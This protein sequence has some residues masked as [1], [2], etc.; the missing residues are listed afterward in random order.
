MQD[1][2]LKGGLDL[3][4]AK[5]L[6]QP[7]YLEDCF[8][9]EVGIEPGYQT[10]GGFERF[11]GHISPSNTD[12]WDVAIDNVAIKPSATFTNSLVISDDTT[13]TGMFF[14]ADGA[15]MF[16]VGDGSDR[17]YQY[18]LS[19]PWNITKAV[20]VVGSDP[21]DVSTDDT[22]PQAMAI[23]PDG[24]RA[25]V[26]GTATDI[27][28]TYVL[29]VNTD[30]NSSWT[31]SA[32]SIDVSTEETS[33]T[34]FTFSTDGMRLFVCG[35]QV[36]EV[37]Q[38]DLPAA[39]TLWM[40]DGV[41]FVPAT[42]N[43]SLDISLY[44]T[45]PTGIQF[46]AGG[47][48]FYV[49]DAGGL[50]RGYSCSTAWDISTATW[51][52]EYDT[53]TAI[54][55]IYLTPDSG[56]LF[57]LHTGAT[58]YVREYGWGFSPNEAIDWE[59][60]GE[61]GSLGV[62]ASTDIGALQTAIRFAYRDSAD[63]LPLGATATGTNGASFK[64]GLFSLYDTSKVLSVAAQD[65]NPQAAWFKPDGLRCY[66]L[67]NTN[68]FVYRYNLTIPWDLD[69]AS[70]HSSYNLGAA[71]PHYGLAFRSDGTQF[72]VSTTTITT[73]YTLTTPWDITTVN[74][75]SA[76]LPNG[77]GIT[78]S[79]DG[80]KMYAVQSAPAASVTYP[81][82]SFIHQ[83]TYATAW[84]FGPGPTASVD[85]SINNL[86]LPGEA[87]EEWAVN[88]IAFADDGLSYY[89]SM[90]LLK[91]IH[92]YTCTTAWDVVGS[93]HSGEWFQHNISGINDL[94]ISGHHLYL[95]S[96]Q[97]ELNQYE[98]YN[99]AVFTPLTGVAADIEEYQD[100]LADV[101]AVFR[102]AI[103][104]TPGSGPV[105][106]QKWYKEQLYAVRDYY[107]FNYRSA[108]WAPLK[109]G[110]HVIVCQHNKSI[111]IHGDEGILREL[112]I[113]AGSNLLSNAAGSVLIEPLTNSF[114]WA[115]RLGD[116]LVNS[117]VAGL[118]EVYFNSGSVEPVRGHEMVGATSGF[119]F[120][121][122]RVELRSG[123]WAVGNA[124]GVVY[125]Y[126]VD[127]GIL[128][129]GE[130]VNNTTT[131]TANVMTLEANP[132]IY[133]AGRGTVGNID[134]VGNLKFYSRNEDGAS[135]A[136]LYRTTREGWEKIPL[137][138]EVRFING[139]AEPT[140]IKF[141]ADTSSATVITSDWAVPTS[142]GVVGAW[143]ASAGTVVDAVD[144]S[145]GAYVVPSSESNALYLEEADVSLSLT[146]FGIE[147]PIG[148]RVVGIE[149]EI[150]AQNIDAASQGAALID[151]Q[152]F[153]YDSENPSAELDGI[154]YKRQAVGDL[155]AA[156][157]AYT[158]GS[159]NDLWGAVIDR[160]MVMDPNF[161]IKCSIEW[162]TGATRTDQRIDLVR[163]R[164]HY[165]E[166][167]QLIYFHDT[168]A[169]AD[170]A[171][172][173]LV[174]VHKES[175]AW[176]GTT[177][178]TGTA[179]GILHIYDLTKPQIPTKNI[180]IRTAAAGAGDLIG[181]AYGNERL[182]SLPGSKLLIAENSKYEMVTENVYARD[183]LEGIYGVN[184]AGPAFCY[185]SYYVR[186]A[187]SGLSPDLDKPRHLALF[188]FRLWLGFKFGESATSVAGDPLLFDGTLNAV[189]TG[190]GRG[191]TGF[192]RLAGKTMGVFTDRS[193]DAVTVNGSD[194]DQ[195]TFSP[196]S[197]SREYTIRN[198]SSQ[199][200]YVDQSGVS[201]PS[202]TEKYGDFEIGRQSALVHPWLL[203]RVQT[204]EQ[205]D[206]RDRT[207][208]VAASVCR[209][210]NQ[211]RL[212]FADGWRMTF[213]L[214]GPDVPPEITKQ[215]LYINGDE[216][217]Y[218]RVL[219]TESEVGADGRERLFF[220]M[221]KNPEYDNREAMGY[222][223]EE[224][225]GLSYD[226]SVYKKWI[227]LSAVSGKD[228]HTNSDFDLVHL[229]GS[230][231]GYAPLKMTSAKDL[232]H[233]ADA[234]DTAEDS[235]YRWALG[236]A[237]NA[238]SSTVKLA[239]FDKDRLTRRGRHLSMRFQS[240]SDRELP[241]ILQL[242]GL[243]ATPLREE[244]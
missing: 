117:N 136:G 11:D 109:V 105:L 213:T 160:D 170:Y 79:A 167:G 152:P 194:F 121:V 52:M 133:G 37:H 76:L 226:G 22:T 202:A 147:I 239:Y 145:G 47:F 129:G 26:L 174:N 78:F 143:D 124:S 189:A 18:R 53:G 201:T 125:A 44:Q 90:P 138:W 102:E 204:R 137:G 234:D 205:P 149:I 208:V 219:A 225:A 141:G 61:T 57:V 218:V 108:F 191:I 157:V 235:R 195:Q 50:V 55:D 177:P 65:T 200:M 99:A 171:T 217:Q 241:H 110:Q 186:F 83:T 69:T 28:Y 131:A 86:G 238:V 4:N 38:Y 74:A 132:V 25:Y 17:L 101:A 96:D 229:F 212:Y 80:T 198:V 31:A 203:P 168:V 140:P 243:E 178:G 10:S 165:V 6:V 199:A 94:F 224:D 56:R 146:G 40:L 227:E 14:S 190:Y 73:R 116:G 106:G 5:P 97:N 43:A 8:N 139:D 64:E 197:G 164:V 87:F 68:D 184:G 172:A 1:I 119:D 185:D 3:V 207:D 103:T 93:E 67:G 120:K 91:E 71:G 161:G 183:D 206:A 135:M 104:P 29:A 215:F 33:P 66:V 176:S 130:N 42:H 84:D 41:T 27:I 9:Y 7:G 54:G 113:T 150:T 19:T 126:A 221:D 62:V 244:R 154:I 23:S 20:L 114:D 162:E 158:F 51:F 112:I 32:A 230:C 175:G 169:V 70:Y 128:L 134:L 237:T 187:R 233:P 236:A 222:C 240:A 2:L 242:I 228:I 46:S 13:P 60:N 153:L 123:S 214:R 34:G 156:A 122:W 180:E 100:L 49:S 220:S 144:T 58:D 81:S 72:F 30:I 193:V 45:N 209:S 115:N 111:E 35:Q 181:D 223:Y 188:Q 15:K 142:E 82:E 155:T 179:T 36:G 118:A 231:H 59:L 232:A 75:T 182:V 192:A 151:V 107:R 77:H 166:Q 92:K 88:G 85:V 39:F 196:E 210:K 16:I 148:A 159:G 216:D 48:V 21:L 211:Y 163:L 95:V 98:L 127:R 173:R 63:R 12:V 24:S 89:L